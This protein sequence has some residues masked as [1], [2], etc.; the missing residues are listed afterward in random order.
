MSKLLLIGVGYLGSY[1]LELLARTPNIGQLIVA[2]VDEDRARLKAN[3]A[4]LG[5][6]L[7]G[8]TP[9]IEHL[10]LNLLDVDRTAEILTQLSPE[11]IVNSTVLQTW[12]KIRELP[13]DLYTR[14][15][16]ASL[17]AWLP[18]HLTLNYKLMLAQKRAGLRIP[19]VNTS[20]PDVVNATLGRVGLAPTIGVGNVDMIV[21]GIRLLVA[22][23]FRIN[24]L[25][26]QVYMVGHHVHFT[27]NTDPVFQKAPFL[28]EIFVD[29]R[30]V[31][32]Q[33]DLE[34]LVSDAVRLYPTGLDFNSV[35]ASS[36]VKNALA[37]LFDQRLL[38]HAPGPCGLPGGY[39]VRI[40]ADRVEILLPEQ[41]RLE[42]AIRVNEEAQ[43][44]DGIAEIRDDGTVLFEDYSVAIM[45]EMLGY[46]CREL[47]I[48]ESE[49]RAN[50][51][52]SKYE[53][54]AAKY[55]APRL[56]L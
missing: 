12:F 5:A 24:P 37:I 35:T 14:L 34:A 15:S 8:A 56:A 10:Q 31:T 1:I 17:G 39:P 22:K 42:E 47:R 11:V 53:D 46:E 21:A 43:H 6:L 41:I 45:K 27:A 19:V 2:D 50:E 44:R 32:E 40:S 3:N 13:L 49:S 51:L 29:G 38:T 25:D 36:A 20:L 16:A 52:L 7:H 33:F 9:K 28:L 4:A 30:R 48:E 23:R 54:F 18:M 55:R 26:A